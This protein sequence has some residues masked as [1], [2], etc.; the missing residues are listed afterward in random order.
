MRGEPSWIL[1]AS[2]KRGCISSPATRRPGKPR[3]LTP[4][5]SRCSAKPAGT[6]RDA[7]S[8]R[9]K[10]ADPGTPTA[11][12]LTFL[13][14]G[15][16][17]TVQRNPEYARPKSRG[18][19]FT[20]EKASAEL[21]FPDGR[22]L[23]KPK[24]VNSAVTALLGIDREQFTRIAMIAQGDFLKLLLASTEERKKIFQKLFHTENY[25]ALQLALKMKPPP[26]IGNAHGPRTASDNIFP[27]SSRRYPSPRTRRGKSEK[28][29]A[30][31]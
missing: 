29:R 8:F 5:P 25:G 16:H 6:R 23:T 28:R 13:Y 22:V 11:V 17:Y 30:A 14:L 4:L 26:S 24:E 15:K 18:E 7:D 31:L 1:S 20:T 12:E 10:Y 2:V 19:G 21:H 9:S 3:S 27:A